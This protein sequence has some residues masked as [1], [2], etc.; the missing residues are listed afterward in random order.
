RLRVAE[1]WCAR[2]LRGLVSRPHAPIRIRGRKEPID[3]YMI[4]AV[5]PRAF[6][7][8]ARG[9]EG[10][11]TKMVG[12]EIELRLLQEAFTLTVED[13]ETQVVTVVGEAG[14]GKSRLLFEFSSWSEL[15]DQTFWLFEARATQ[16]SMLQPYSL[17]RDLF[18]LRFQILDSDP[19]DVVHDK[20]VEGVAGFLGPGSEAKAELIG[21]LVGFDFSHLP[22]VAEA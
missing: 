20:F 15:N 1:G 13:G 12:R 8:K 4:M 5:K 9:I 6:R 22:V 17:T 11:E 2:V 16:P 21:Q 7:L 19:L 18:S 14:V 3:V 10:V